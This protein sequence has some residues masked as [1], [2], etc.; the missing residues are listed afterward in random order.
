MKSVWTLEIE[1]DVQ[2]GVLVLTLSGR[3]G[4]ASAGELITAGMAA[5]DEGHRAILIDLGGVDYM[6]SAGLIAVDALA[7]RIRG[8]AAHL[9]LC[10]A[11]DPVRLVLE[12]GGVLGDVPLEPSR[13]AGLERLRRDHRPS[14]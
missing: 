11:C 9:V 2:D 4:T 12:F 7:G 10:R 14:V 8:G 1:R 3:L 13:D 5:L 6:S